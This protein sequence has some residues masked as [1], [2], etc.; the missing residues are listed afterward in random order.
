MGVEAALSLLAPSALI[1][2]FL[3]FLH[4]APYERRALQSPPLSCAPQDTIVAIRRGGTSLSITS[5][6]PEIYP[7]MQFGTDP[8]QVGL[9]LGRARA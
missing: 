2:L 3:H 1:T 7:D 6:T 4:G 8:N 9:G 5:L